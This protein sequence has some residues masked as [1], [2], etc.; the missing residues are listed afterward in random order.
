M[1]PFD[2]S[3]LNECNEG[4][5]ESDVLVAT[6]EKCEKLQKKLDIAI[7]ALNSIVSLGGFPMMNMD[8]FADVAS[9]ALCDIANVDGKKG[10]NL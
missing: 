3:S 4:K 5:R 6:I 10:V 2:M 1:R 9:D 7:E 8:R